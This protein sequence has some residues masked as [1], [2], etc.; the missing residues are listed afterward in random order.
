MI[1]K[2]KSIK[3]AGNSLNYVM[4]E[5]KGEVLK[6]SH[7]LG[8]TPKEI[9]KEFKMVQDLNGRCKNNTLSFVVSPSIED[10]KDLS[11]EDFKKLGEDF[12]KEM[13]LESR[14]SILI[15]HTDKNHQHLH[16]YVNRIDFDGK[17][18]ND[19]K[20][21]IRSQE[22]AYS[23]GKERGFSQ[24]KDMAIN[25]KQIMK[26]RLHECLK[27]KPKNFEAFKSLAK[28]TGLDL[29]LHTNKSGKAV[30]YRVTAIKKPEISFTASKISK[31]LVLPKINKVFAMASRLSRGLGLGLK[32]SKDF[33]LGM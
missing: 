10:G 1:G 28:E 3:H 8:E 21:G 18:Y 2:G 24:A 32:K 4:Q 14:Q 6:T 11:N 27:Q 26:K 5:N 9:E 30:G 31:E 13:K 22:K 15:K 17:A 20:I 23:I 25:H 16:I 29:K 33:G 12:L 7:L 19:S